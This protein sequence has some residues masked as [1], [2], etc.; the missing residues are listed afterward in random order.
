MDRLISLIIGISALVLG[1]PLGLFIACAA[2]EEIESGQRWFKIII[3]ASLVG[4][5]ACLIL[6]VDALFFSFLFFTVVT[7]ASLKHKRK[8]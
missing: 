1:Y 2:K 7:S 3:I 6:N 8:R 4:A 5:F